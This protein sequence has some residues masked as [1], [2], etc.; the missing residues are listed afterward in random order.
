MGDK[1]KHHFLSPFKAG[2]RAKLFCHFFLC[3]KADT[4]INESQNNQTL[5]LSGLS[6]REG[7]KSSC[8]LE[9]TYNLQVGGKERGTAESRAGDCWSHID[10]SQGAQEK[11]PG[12]QHQGDQQKF[13]SLLLSQ[14]V[15]GILAASWWEAMEGMDDEFQVFIPGHP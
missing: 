1:Q 12:T 3:R 10:G 6:F 9:G 5:R 2:H 4:A 13:Q 15:L 8:S 11:H 7:L 14:L